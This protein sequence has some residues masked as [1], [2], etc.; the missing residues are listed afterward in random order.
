MPWPAPTDLVT[1][2]SLLALFEACLRADGASDAGARVYQPGDWPTQPGQ[3][4]VIKLRILREHRVSQG[5]SGAPA[6]TTTTT[7]RVIGEVEAYASEDNAGATMAEAACWRLK[8][9]I[10]VA[11]VN[12]HDLFMRIQQIA[13]IDSQLVLN[14]EGATHIAAI[15]MDFAVEFFEGADSF[16]PDDADDITEMDFTPTPFPPAT[17]TFSLTP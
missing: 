9:Q 17:A 16:H 13:S 6:Y 10:E 8:R 5:R 2:Q 7:I 11:I 12:A 3:M 1:S 4:P 15:V 14:A